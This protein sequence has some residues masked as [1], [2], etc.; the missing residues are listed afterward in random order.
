MKI[1]IVCNKGRK[2]SKSLIDIFKGSINKK[3]NIVNDSLRLHDSLIKELVLRTS[4]K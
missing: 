2:T 4:L 3:S 1:I